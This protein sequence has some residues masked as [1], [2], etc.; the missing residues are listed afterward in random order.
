MAK[1]VDLQFHEEDETWTA[2]VA[3]KRLKAQTPRMLSGE[4]KRALETDDVETRIVLDR[5]MERAIEAHVKKWQSYKKERQKLDVILDKLNMEALDIAKALR[6]RQCSQEQ[7]AK[8]LDRH[9]TSITSLLDSRQYAGAR[10]RALKEGKIKPGERVV[11]AGKS[12]ED[13]EGD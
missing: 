8:R 2:E 4:V 11:R 7:I 13:D 9:T 12:A 1:V 10:V 3:G 6:L 5:A